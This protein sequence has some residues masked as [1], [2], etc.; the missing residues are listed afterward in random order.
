MAGAMLAAC[1]PA[2]DADEGDPNTAPATPTPPTPPGDGTLTPTTGGARQVEERTDLFIFEYSYPQAAGETKG[3][4]DWLDRRL[5]RERSSLAARAE[6]GRA[7]ARDNGFPFNTYSSETAWEVVADM[8]NWLSL[9]ADQSYYY[10][11]AHPNYGFDTIVWNKEDGTPMEPTAFFTSNAAL[12]EALGPRLCEALNAEREKRRGIPVEEDAGNSFNTCIKPDETNLLLGS[13]NGQT[14]NR[15]GIQIA[16]YLAGPYAEGSY[17]F[18][19]PMTPELLETVREE[20]REV[21]A[22]R[23]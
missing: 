22:A 18:T 3:L 1:V 7:E 10:G 8:P 12:D 16:P 6:D 17:E 23:N 5:D 9:S 15:I 13:T 4:A 21:F 14:F 19:F 2:D 11:G 20:Y